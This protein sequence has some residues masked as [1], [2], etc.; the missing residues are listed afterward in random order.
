MSTFQFN[1]KFIATASSPVSEL[2]FD[3]TADIIDLTGLS[4]GG[5]DVAVGDTVFLDCSGSGS[6][7]GTVSR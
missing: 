5:L 3:V 7:P 4:N 2:E 6:A 1:A